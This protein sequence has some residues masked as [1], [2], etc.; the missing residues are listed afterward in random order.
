MYKLCTGKL[1]AATIADQHIKLLLGIL[2]TREC[3]LQLNT[4]ALGTYLKTQQRFN[5]YLKTKIVYTFF[6]TTKIAKLM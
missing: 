4:K 2:P 3:R 5:K 1:H 6:I